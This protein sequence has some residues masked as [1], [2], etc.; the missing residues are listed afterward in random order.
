MPYQSK[1]HR[2]DINNGPGVTGIVPIFWPSI[3][4]NWTRIM[5]LPRPFQ[6]WV[7]WKIHLFR[8]PTCGFLVGAISAQEL[9][10]W[11]QP[12]DDSS[13]GPLLAPQRLF[14]FD[15]N[16]DSSPSHSNLVSKYT[17]VHVSYLWFPG[18]CHICPRVTLTYRWVRQHNKAWRRCISQHNKA[19]TLRM[20]NV[21]GRKF[22]EKIGEKEKEKEE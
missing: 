9:Q 15:S 16:N 18:G 12:G 20:R 2:R 22:T 17:S 8:S 6:S 13:S 1:G 3:Y 19:K 5:A 14:E 11:F 7:R 21:D 4:S 10:A